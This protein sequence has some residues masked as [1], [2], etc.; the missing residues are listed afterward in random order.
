M[1]DTG[2]D[3]PTLGDSLA[4]RGIS[5]RSLLKYA[6]YLA[7]LMALPPMASRAMAEA[8]AGAGRQSVIWLSFQECTGC[9]ESLTRSFSPTIEDMIFNLISLDYSET[10]MAASGTAAE[11]ARLAA[12]EANKGKFILV[13]DGSVSTRD[14]GIYSTNAGK[15][16]LA[17]LK[18]TAAEAAAVISV[19][20]CA[21]FGGIPA[22][23]PNPTGAVPVSEIVT[24]KPVVN[25]S[26]CPPIPDAIAGT[27]AYFITFGKLPELDHLNRPR[28][29]FGDSIHDR[30]YRR[31]YYDKGLF[32]KSFDDEG[33]RNGWCLYEV[34][35]KG[36]VTYNAC[37]T[38]KWNGGVSFPI[39]SGHGCLGCS[40]P[41][42]WD[43]G[44]FYKPLSAS[45]MGNNAVL[46]GAAA[47]GLVAGAASVAMAR[48]RRAAAMAAA[49]KPGET[50]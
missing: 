29:F 16:N 31:P 25:I 34:G 26:G 11:E 8:L 14:D 7:G 3:R 23:R 42:F 40:E 28:A 47:A 12:M 49:S 5:R 38:L 2:Q 39:Q 33:A 15:T 6:G 35:C 37:A 45:V 43:Q 36:P 18:E 48:R 46:G 19:G 1:P 10:L 13:V 44:G 9:V 32:A 50:K 22:A 41:G 27:I 4:A 17:V 30:C 20:T 24:D 21:A